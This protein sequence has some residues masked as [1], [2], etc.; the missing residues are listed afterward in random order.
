MCFNGKRNNTIKS[1]EYDDGR[2]TGEDI[3]MATIAKEYFKNLFTSMGM[4]N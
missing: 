1:L 3:Q 2:T 4:D